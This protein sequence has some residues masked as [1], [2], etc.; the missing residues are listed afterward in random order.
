MANHYESQEDT[1]SDFYPD[2]PYNVCELDLDELALYCQAEGHDLT[3]GD[4]IRSIED[5]SIELNFHSVE[6]IDEFDPLIAHVVST[7]IVENIND[8]TQEPDVY[9]DEEEEDDYV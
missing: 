2:Q 3:V 9:L 8:F 5:G 1:M 7:T 4:I 6:I